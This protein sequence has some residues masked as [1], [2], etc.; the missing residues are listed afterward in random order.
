MQKLIKTIPVYTSSLEVQPLHFFFLLVCFWTIADCVQGLLLA[1]C[2]GITSDWLGRTD[3]MGW[4]QGWKLSSKWAR[5]KSYLLSSLD[6]TLQTV[7]TSFSSYKLPNIFIMWLSV[8][9]IFPVLGSIS[10]LE[11]RAVKRRKCNEMC[12]FKVLLTPFFLPI[13]SPI[14]IQDT[15]FLLNSQSCQISL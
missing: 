13:L 4:C 11:D 2:S 6:P 14:S 7:G 9:Q 8:K 3:L 5:Q 15:F 1:M 12:W 10:F